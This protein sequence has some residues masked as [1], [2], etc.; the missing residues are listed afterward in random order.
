MKKNQRE[1]RRTLKIIESL[2]GLY[3]DARVTP[4]YNNAFQ[5]LVAT[6]L[7]AQCT[8]KKVESLTPELFRKYRTV[9]S[10]ARLRPATLAKDIYSIGLYRSKAANIVAASR[11][12]IKD[13]NGKVPDNMKALVVLPG[14]GRKTANIVLGTAYKK[15][16]GIA[17]DTHVARLSRRLH[18]T[19]HK[20]PHKIERDLTQLIPKTEWL[21]FNHLLVT[22]G[23]RICRARA[24]FCCQCI[25]RGLCP[26]NKYNKR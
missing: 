19:R 1:L 11:Q 22:H 13:H 21:G 7:S 3:P 15:A 5:L 20:Y 4:K 23:R 8:D 10:F 2:K 16:E 6:I 25:I 9:G 18:L 14:V 12:I 24:P 26:P 17:V